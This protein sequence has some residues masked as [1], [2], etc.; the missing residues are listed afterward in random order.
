MQERVLPSSAVGGS[1]SRLSLSLAPTPQ[2]RPRQRLHRPSHVQQRR[3]GVDVHRPVVP[4]CCRRTI[5]PILASSNIKIGC[6]AGGRGELRNAEVFETLLG[7]EVLVERWRVEYN[8]L[9]PHI[10]LGYRPPAPEAVEPWE[11]GGVQRGLLPKARLSCLQDCL[12]SQV[13]WVPRSDR[14]S[15]RDQLPR[16]NRGHGMAWLR[17]STPRHGWR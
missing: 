7:A 8:P 14:R 6:V 1:P 2:R 4:E 15:G 16:M 12:N 9:R 5:P 3:I 10:A 17:C 11:G 13:A